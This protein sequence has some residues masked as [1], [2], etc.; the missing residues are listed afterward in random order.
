MTQLNLPA[1]A[2]SSVLSL[3]LGFL[4]FTL[5][6]REPYIAGLGRTAEQ[7]SQGPS[8]LVAS[9]YQLLGSAVMAGV[10]A[11]LMKATSSEGLVQAVQLAGLIWAG[12]VAAVIGPM[13]AYQAFSLVFFGITA[14]YPF[15]A[16][17]LSAAVLSLWR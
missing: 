13:Y 1:V 14:G 11:F 5:I 8:V 17:L 15:V 4:W 10:L 9:L 7:L 12:F 16:L 6:F 2:L 3:L